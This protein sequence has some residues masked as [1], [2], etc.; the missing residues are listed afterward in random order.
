M[1]RYRFDAGLVE[2]YVGLPGSGKSLACGGMVRDAHRSGV[3]V[4]ANTPVVIDGYL[5]PLVVVDAQARDAFR[6]SRT[7]DGRDVLLLSE[8]HHGLVFLDEIQL[9][10]PARRPLALPMAWLEW[11]SQTRKGYDDDD[12][13][14]G[15]HVIW[16]TQNMLNV[17]AVMRRVSAFITK[18]TRWELPGIG[19][20]FERNTYEAQEFG[21]PRARRLGPAQRY[22][23]LSQSAAAV[24]N[25]RARVGVA[26]HLQENREPTQRPATAMAGPR[27]VLS[28]GEAFDLLRQE[29]PPGELEAS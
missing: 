21:R 22:T 12:E 23:R 25:T 3:P 18:C 1:S 19:H 13:E 27:R 7:Y 10:M 8:I 5:A 2:G 9:W 6:A 26:S 20:V 17:D 15:V 29:L 16:A 4:F 28:P 14:G 24:F 11:S